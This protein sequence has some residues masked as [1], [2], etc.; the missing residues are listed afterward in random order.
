MKVQKEHVM[1]FMRQSAFFAVLICMV[2]MLVQQTSLSAYAM[3]KAKVV[4]DSGKI[5][6]GAGTDSEAKASVVKGDE[7]DI[8]A[9]TKDSN[10]I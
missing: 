4:A 2:L 3:G 8:I 9:Q 10:D 6:A 1:K 5:R 7:L